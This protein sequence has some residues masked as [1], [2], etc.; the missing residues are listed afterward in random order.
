MVLSSL[1]LCPSVY[2]R[3]KNGIVYGFVNGQVFTV[4]GK[5][6]FLKK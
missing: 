1:G 2:G 4:D 5:L 6:Y 3:F